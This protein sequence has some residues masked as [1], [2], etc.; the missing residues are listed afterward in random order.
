MVYDFV[1]IIANIYQKSN[2]RTTDDVNTVS[3]SAYC[4]TETEYIQ[5][6]DFYTSSQK[7]KKKEQGR[8][9]VL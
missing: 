6:V 1:T 4:V 9:P 5:S 7:S 8:D 2:I 3:N